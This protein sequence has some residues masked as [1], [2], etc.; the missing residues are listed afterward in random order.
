MIVF[1]KDAQKSYGGF[2]YGHDY[3]VYDPENPG[4]TIEEIKIILQDHQIK[5]K[6]AE[7]QNNLVGIGLLA[8]FL[9]FAFSE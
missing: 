2:E 3:I 7:Q 6:K 9:L 1:D 8:A 4:P 5:M